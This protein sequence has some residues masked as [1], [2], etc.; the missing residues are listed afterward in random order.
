MR[1]RSAQ[2]AFVVV[3]L[4]M[5]AGMLFAQSNP[6]VGTWKLEVAK[7]KFRPGPAPRGAIRTW[8]PSGKINVKG[9]GG[10]GKPISYG[11]MFRADGKLHPTW[12]SIPNG[13]SSVSSKWL[14][15]KT[16]VFHF[17]RHGRRI[18]RT[19]YTLSNGG[20]T[21]TM[22]AKG[23]IPNGTAF[24]NVMVWSRQ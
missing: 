23:T 24:N 20:K 10:T 13:S 17:V 21:L 16:V 19:T 4:L 1:R 15:A 18:E 7:S 9:I 6:F 14:N 8:S 11:Y 2:F 3:A 22:R 12:G 5:S